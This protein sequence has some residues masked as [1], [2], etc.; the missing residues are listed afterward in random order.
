MGRWKSDEELFETV[1]RELFTCAVG[2]IMDTMRLMHQY[3]PPAIRPL[4]Q[5]M[6]LIGR[7]MP[8]LS[9]DVF[10][11]RVD[12]SANPLSSKPF[13]PYVGGAR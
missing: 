8:V 2:D 5:D 9:G 3:L 4:R 12:G 7:A 10:Q 1:R 13:G 11:E 6:T